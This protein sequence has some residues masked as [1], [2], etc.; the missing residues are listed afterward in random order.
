[1]FRFL[2]D[3]V[4]PPTRTAPP[5]TPPPVDPGSS[6]CAAVSTANVPNFGLILGVIAAVVL[7]TVLL[8]VFRNKKAKA[9]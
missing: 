4:F 6:S 9:R 8:I 2:G 3:L 7:F 1:M 5:V